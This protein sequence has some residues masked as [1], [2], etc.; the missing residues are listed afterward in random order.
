MTYP[1]GLRQVAVEM[2]G[3]CAIKF[4]FVRVRQISPPNSPSKFAAQ[5]G[6]S[7]FGWS[8]PTPTTWWVFLTL[9]RPSW[10]PG[11]P[12]PGQRPCHWRLAKISP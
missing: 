1:V 4:G 2:G 3:W 8:M 11:P 6:N 10:C 9:S 5:A 7:K 12:P